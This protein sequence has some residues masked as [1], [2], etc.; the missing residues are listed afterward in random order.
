MMGLALPF[1]RGRLGGEHGHPR[2]DLVGVG[3]DDFGVQTLGQ[4]KREGGFADAGGAGQIEDWEFG[5]FDAGSLDGFGVGAKKKG[6][7]GDGPF[8]LK[9]SGE[10]TARAAATARRGVPRGGRRPWR[11]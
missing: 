7:P 2:V 4:G 11:R 9:L 8:S 1:L 5:V 10:L 6:P 3:A